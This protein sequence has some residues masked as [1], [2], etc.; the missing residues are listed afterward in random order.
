MNMDKGLNKLDKN[1]LVVKGNPLIQA[2][3]DDL[4]SIEYKIIISAISTIKPNY[5]VL[6]PIEFGAK[7]FCN[8]LKVNVDGMYTYLKDSCDKLIKR[9]ITLEKNKNWK[10]FSWLYSIE[11]LDGLIILKFHPNLEPYLLFCK[12]NNMY[13]KYLLENIIDMNSKYSIRIFEL[14]KQYEKIGYRIFELDELKKLLGVKNKYA[15]FSNFKKKVLEISK[16]EINGLTDI[17][18]NF[19]EIK[20]GRKV[21]Q[22]KYL[23]GS[24]KYKMTGNLQYNLIPK[25]K[26]ISILNKKIYDFTGYVF[27]F[28]NLNTYHR[29]V[30]IDLIKKFDNNSF[31]KVLIKYPNA[32]F[33]WH[34]DDISKNYDLSKLEDY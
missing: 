13:T 20:K 6:D 18:I 15:K 4:S 11:Y 25:L 32:F 16:E 3:I 1:S 29:I 9:T 26:L 10:K 22:I 28:K 12:E 33:K 14:T 27:N 5:T 8:L 19:E 17:N 24:K 30:L 31:D 21:E 34:L 7:D 2:Y 23:I